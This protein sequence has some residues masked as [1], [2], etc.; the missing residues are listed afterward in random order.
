MGRRDT[1]EVVWKRG[2][3]SRE[4]QGE[5]S[6]KS[7]QRTL[8]AQEAGRFNDEIITTTVT[9]RFDDKK[10]GETTKQQISLERDE[11]NRPGTT[12]E[13][14]AALPP[15]KG[16]GGFITAGNASQLSDGASACVLMEPKQA[17]ER[18]LHPLGI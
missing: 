14:L 7:Q 3:I 12:L 4:A 18:G 8:A 6:V 1:A 17:D 9:K 13:G 10:T 16:P 2:K 5:D 11:C 15:V